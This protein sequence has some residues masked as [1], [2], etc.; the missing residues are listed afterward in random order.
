MLQTSDT[1]LSSLA[2]SAHGPDWAGLD[3]VSTAPV[4]DGDYSFP[5]PPPPPPS[6]TSFSSSSFRTIGTNTLPI[7]YINMESWALMLRVGR[8]EDFYMVMA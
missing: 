4:T 1:R 3:Q 5:P 8:D 2:K 7:R 6:S